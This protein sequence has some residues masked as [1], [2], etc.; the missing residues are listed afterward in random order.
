MVND[1][2]LLRGTESRGE[3]ELFLKGRLPFRIDIVNVKPGQT[4][5][6]RAMVDRVGS[7]DFSTATTGPQRE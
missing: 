6:F 3:R 4:V 2:F 1:V 5:S 7:L